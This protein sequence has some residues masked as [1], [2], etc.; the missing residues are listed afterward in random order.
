MLQTTE[1]HDEAF[2]TSQI[3]EIKCCHV[4]KCIKYIPTI[5]HIH[6]LDK[7]MVKEFDIT[8]LKSNI[9]GYISKGDKV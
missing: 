2:H 6:C 4:M 8:G 7:V 1:K 9:L 3:L 5:G